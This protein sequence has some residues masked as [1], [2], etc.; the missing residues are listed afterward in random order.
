M[1]P[2]ERERAALQL[3]DEHLAAGRRIY[4]RQLVLTQSLRERGMSTVEAEQLCKTMAY[5]LTL[6]RHHRTQVW[7]HVLDLTPDSPES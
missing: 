5:S 2:L 1:T 3:A 4:Q 6:M 7:H